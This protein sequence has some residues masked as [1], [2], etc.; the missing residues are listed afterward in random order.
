MTKF[1]NKWQEV[2]PYADVL[3]ADSTTPGHSIPMKVS[4]NG[5]PGGVQNRFLGCMWN[6]EFRSIGL[7]FRNF[8]TASSSNLTVTYPPAAHHSVSWGFPPLCLGVELHLPPCL[9]PPWFPG[10]SLP[11]CSLHLAHLFQLK[12]MFP[13]L[14][15]FVDS[16]GFERRV[17]IQGG[18]GVFGQ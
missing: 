18:M 12:F 6:L 10:Y 1:Q 3:T 16:S 5:I 14:S 2:P 7:E 9:V 13:V 15:G 17:Q 4:V 8:L 11:R